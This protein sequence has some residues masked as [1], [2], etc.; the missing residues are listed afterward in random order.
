MKILVTGF[1]LAAL[2]LASA[3]AALPPNQTLNDAAFGDTAFVSVGANGTIYTS[4]N[5]GPWELR[6]SGTTNSL[7]AV[8]YGDGMFVAAGAR[9]TILSSSNGIDWVVRAIGDAWSTPDIAFGNG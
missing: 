5:S 9:G 4:V 3:A 6:V 1:A 2:G 7:L 8:A